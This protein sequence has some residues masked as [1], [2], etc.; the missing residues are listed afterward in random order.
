MEAVNMIL[1]GVLK[2]NEKN[3]VRVSFS[4]GSD[5]AEGIVPDGIIEK[6]AGFTDEEVWELQ[7]YMTSNRQEIIA[8]AKKINPIRSWLGK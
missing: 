3:F 4:R 8:Q 7:E 6:S 2:K 5:F 1:S